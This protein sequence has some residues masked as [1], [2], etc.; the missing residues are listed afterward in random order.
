[1]K[2]ATGELSMTAIVVV[3]LAVVAAIAPIIIRTVGNTIK[4]RTVCA[5]AYGCNTGTQCSYNDTKKTW[6]GQATC[7]YQDDNGDEKTVKCDCAD[8][9]KGTAN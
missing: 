9:L 3:I 2:E 1:M 4:M 8:L 7:S 6:T 5:A